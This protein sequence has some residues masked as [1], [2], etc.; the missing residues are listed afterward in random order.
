MA[1]GDGLTSPQFLLVRV[2]Q[3]WHRKPAGGLGFRVLRFIGF[4]GLTFG[5][6]GWE[7]V[8]G[9]YLSDMGLGFR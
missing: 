8:V 7:G 4:C 6:G 2:Y 3:V 5:L 9:S 1:V